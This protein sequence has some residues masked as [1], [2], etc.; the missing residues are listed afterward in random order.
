MIR[1]IVLLGFAGLLAFGATQRLS[2][3]I[4]VVAVELVVWGAFRYRNRNHDLSA[5]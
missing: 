4:A 2:M 3:G 5:Q 1:N